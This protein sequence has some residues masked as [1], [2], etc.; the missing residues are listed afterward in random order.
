MGVPKRSALEKFEGSFLLGAL[1]LVWRVS[2][3][4]NTGNSRADD[5][6]KF[7]IW[8]GFRPGDAQTLEIL[9]RGLLHK[10]KTRE[11][12][13]FGRPE[14]RQTRAT[15]VVVKSDMQISRVRSILERP[16]LGNSQTFDLRNIFRLR[17]SRVWGAPGSTTYKEKRGLRKREE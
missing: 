1:W 17:I 16:N 5:F 6:L 3:R 4:S 13:M 9:E 8:A 10:S 14:T 2:G 15:E 7:W 12:P 11:F